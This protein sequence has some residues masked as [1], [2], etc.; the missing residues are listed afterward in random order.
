MNAGAFNGI[1]ALWLGL[2][3]TNYGH[4]KW[5][6]DKISWSVIDSLHTESLFKGFH[7]CQYVKGWINGIE[8]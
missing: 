2:F 8:L 6:K 7:W 1:K 4:W 3:G 5:N